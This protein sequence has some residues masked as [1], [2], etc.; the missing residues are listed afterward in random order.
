VK[1]A[2]RA[3]ALVALLESDGAARRKAVLEPAA[4]QARELLRHARTS[5]RM[6]VATAIAEE[7][8][9]YAARVEG[10]QARL[11]TARRMAEQ[12][13]MRALAADGW[14]RL[15][16]AMVARWKDEAGRRAWV[17]AAIEQAS[18]LLRAP[19]WSIRTTADWS[20]E[21][22]GRTAMELAARGIEVSFEGDASIAAG[23]VITGGNVEIDASL[24]G[25]L[26]DRLAVQ[27]RLLALT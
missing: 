25:L 17:G 5:S 4:A 19:R 1:L 3:A 15:A 10:A 22:R 7:R 21:E 18:A 24:A 20:E 23:L 26:A 6:R 16:P 2:D 8:A 14:E 27:G 12:R 13:R 11:D 9:A